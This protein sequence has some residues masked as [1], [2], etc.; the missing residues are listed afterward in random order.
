MLQVKKEN[1]SHL[2]GASIS[3]S[4]SFMSSVPYMADF[5]YLKSYSSL[6][7]VSCDFTILD[8]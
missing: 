4:T 3:P 1:S 2:I 7:D 5:D 8:F 6:I